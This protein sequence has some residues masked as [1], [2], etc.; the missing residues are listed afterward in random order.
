MKQIAG[1][2]YNAEKEFKLI[3]PIILMITFKTLVISGLSIQ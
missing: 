1:E 3:K 2:Q